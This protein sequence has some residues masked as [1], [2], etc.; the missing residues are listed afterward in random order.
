AGRAVAAALSHAGA[1][2]TLV[3]RGQERGQLAVQLLGLPFVSLSKFT[4]TG[5]AIVVNATPVGRDDG[6]QPFE[7]EEL[8]ADAVVVDLVYG[9]KPTPLVANTL[10]RGRVVIDGRE[11]LLTQVR[12]QFRLMTDKKMPVG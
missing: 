1:R 4:A 11:V 12:R 7:I 3:N 8:S 2:V 5:Y 6:E 9:S 10:E